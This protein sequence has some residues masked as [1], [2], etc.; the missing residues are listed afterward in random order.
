[1]S[2]FT[3]NI[4]VN[5][6]R[7]KQYSHQGQTFIESK[8]GSEYVIEIKN[9]IWSR[10]M[11]I[12][13][14]DGLNIIDGK[15]A[16]IDGPGYIID[17][18][19]SNKYDGFRISDDKIAKFIFSK[20]QQ[21]Y[22]ASKNDGSE[23]NVGVIGI[24]I[25]DEHIQHYKSTTPIVYDTNDID[26]IFC[27]SSD[28]YSTT[29]SSMNIEKSLP[30]NKRTMKKSIDTFDMGTKWGNAKESKVIEVDFQKGH[31]IFSLDIYY[32]SRE[33]L[34]NL[35]IP[36]IKKKQISFPSAFPNKYAT[37]PKGWTG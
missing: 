27:C 25:F 33:S 36:L 31:Q 10:V 17:E 15:S 30:H 35:G 9:N 24:K 37:P 5:G 1:M 3:V 12:C 7:C 14:V 8:D 11:A 26:N 4:L 29:C 28:T 13:S 34:I 22:A 20:K 6:S 23:Q 21:S 19:S 16:H 18:Y 2:N 32:A